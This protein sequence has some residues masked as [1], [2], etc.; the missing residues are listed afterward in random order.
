MVVRA[1]TFLIFPV[2]KRQFVFLF[3]KWLGRRIHHPLP[4]T[5]PEQDNISTMRKHDH[6][7]KAMAQAGSP[8]AANQEPGDAA[9]P[10]VALSPILLKQFVFLKEDFDFCNDIIMHL[11]VDLALNK[12]SDI[13]QAELVALYALKLIRAKDKGDP[14]TAEIYDRMI[15]AHLK[16]LR[17]SKKAREGAATASR[18]HLSDAEPK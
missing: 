9:Q 12:S 8:T 1:D 3:G 4:Q 10:N 15:R 7:D 13:M 11:Y 17:A 5:T 14:A 6:I 18:P 16:D 2:S